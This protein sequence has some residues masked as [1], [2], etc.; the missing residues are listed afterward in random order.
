MCPKIPPDC[1]SYKNLLLKLAGSGFGGGAVFAFSFLSSS[2]VS[3]SL[4]QS[5]LDLKEVAAAVSSSE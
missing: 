2:H 4:S 3:L 1:N 5:V